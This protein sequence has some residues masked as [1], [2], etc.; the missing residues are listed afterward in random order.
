MCII[1]RISICC[2]SHSSLFN[3]NSRIPE[4]KN[5][6]L[7][8]VYLMDTG[9]ICCFLLL[10]ITCGHRYSTTEKVLHPFSLSAQMRPP[11]SFTMLSAIDS[12]RP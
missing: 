10:F 8:P 2:T 11:C 5:K 6:T 3:S 7:P 4:Q 12:P 1:L 9:G